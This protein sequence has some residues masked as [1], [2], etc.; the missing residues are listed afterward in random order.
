MRLVF[1]TAAIMRLLPK[2]MQKVTYPLL[3]SYWETRR[4]LKRTNRLLSSRIQEIMEQDEDGTQ[5]PKGSSIDDANVL[6][7]L[8]NAVKEKDHHPDVVSPAL[9][10]LALASV[11]TTLSRMVHVLYDVTAAGNSLQEQLITEIETV[12]QSDWTAA[13]YEKLHLL[14]S[15]LRESQRLSPPSTTGMKRVFLESYTF[16]DGTHIPKGTYTCLP[17]YAIEN[18]KE[19]APQPQ[20]FDGLRSFRVQEQNKRLHRP[21]NAVAKELLFATPTET[22]LQFGYGKW[23]CPGR[24]FASFAIKAVLVKL[25]SEYEFRFLPNSGRPKNLEFHEFIFPP[26]SQRMLVRRKKGALGPF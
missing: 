11:H 4:H 17:I 14:D 10:V 25:F 6:Y 13:S 3:P 20:E 21:S 12:S 1:T 8:S 24:F 16:H 9:L 2:W 22:S 7:W 15:V 26:A 5:Q 23:A 19:H 18:D